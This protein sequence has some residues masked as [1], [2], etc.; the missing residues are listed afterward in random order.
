[1]T[2]FK[3]GTVYTHMFLMVQDATGANPHIA[4]K[5]G[6]APVASCTIRNM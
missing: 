4:G 3:V 1:M 6:A 5:T 2:D